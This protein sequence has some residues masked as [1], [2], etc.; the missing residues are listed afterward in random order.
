MPSD[1]KWSLLPNTS[2]INE[3]NSKRSS[4]TLNFANGKLYVFGG[5]HQPRTP[6]DSNFVMY[7]L[8]SK[9]WSTNELS[10]GDVPEARVGHSACSLGDFI[11]IFGGRNGVDLGENSLNDLYSF[12]T[13]NNKWT[14]LC[15]G[16]LDGCPEKR[17]YHTMAGLG[18]KIY[19]FGGCSVNHG[20]LNDLHEFNL[21][22]KQWT[23]LPT[24]DSILPRGGTS[25]CSYENADEKC[26]YVIGGFAGMELDD[27][28]KFNLI[29]KSW[30]SIQNLPRKLSVFALASVKN[31]TTRLILHG[32]EVDPSTLGHNGAGEF[33]KETFLFDGT[34][35]NAASK[36]VLNSG[37]TSRG[38]HSGCSDHNGNF[39]I[40]GGNLEDNKRSDE[41]WCLAL[42]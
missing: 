23:R 36:Q 5:E 27:C 13:I 3:E 7:D 14:L 33:T 20:R 8:Q 11:Y 16:K 25:L 2:N 38:W 30:S 37:P 32:G 21:E 42:P 6:I 1:F 26:L 28:Y 18:N 35:W 31:S 4:H 29:D 39:Y 24:N 17:S 12:D 9:S 22:T 10:N 15:D 34:Q 40:Y 41:L 19:V